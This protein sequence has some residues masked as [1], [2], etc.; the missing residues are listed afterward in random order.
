MSSIRRLKNN[1]LFNIIAI[2]AIPIILFA[3]WV[4]AS[5]I[6]INPYGFLAI[7]DQSQKIQNLEVPEERLLKGQK[8]TG[9]F[10]AQENNLGIVELKLKTNVAYDFEK[11]DILVFRIK[12]KD[13]KD[14]IT[15]NLYRTDLLRRTHTLP[16][17]IPKLADSRGKVYFFEIESSDGNTKNALFVS[18]S[19]VNI[20]QV[21]ILQ[22][23]EVLSSKKNLLAFFYKKTIANIQNWDFI[24]QSLVF[25]LPLIIY[26]LS[27]GFL[28]KF[29]APEKLVL[30][31]TTCLTIIDILFLGKEYIGI[32]I[33]L[34]LLWGICV[35]LNH[36]TYKV[37][38]IISF[39]LMGLWLMLLIS[40]TTNYQGKLNIWT[41]IFLVFGTVQ[42]VLLE[43]RIHDR[44]YNYFKTIFVKT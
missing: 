32:T 7:N 40:N 11:E 30:I 43:T 31:M 18:P 21:Y 15:T 37:T 10:Q 44:V 3:L 17:G 23:E 34:F 39:S 29:K 14:W 12:E 8:I 38:F 1:K 4:G 26:L 6:F 22:K 19:T 5:T 2:F 33:F 13:S 25:S 35:Y 16:M 41:Y 36:F 27:L 42:I 28:Y 24:L 20:S 9:F